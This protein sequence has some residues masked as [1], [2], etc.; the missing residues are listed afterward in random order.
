V[1]APALARGQVIAET[2]V[3][4]QAHVRRHGIRERQAATRARRD[5]LRATWPAAAAV[6]SVAATRRA[7]VDIAQRWQDQQAD[8]DQRE[9]MKSGDHQD[10]LIRA[11]HTE[12]LPRKTGLVNGFGNSSLPSTTAMATKTETSSLNVQRRE[13]AGS[14][15]VR[16]LRRAGNVPGVIYGGGADPVAFQVDARL[17]RNTLAHSHAV[18]ELQVESEKASPVVVKEVARHPVSGEITHIDL[19]RVRMDQKISTTVVLDLVGAESAPG[20]IEGGIL[21]QVTRELNI[22]ALPGDIPDAVH[23]DVSG[24]ESGAT[25]T[26]SEL[27]PPRGVAFLDDPELV[28]ATIT[29]PRLQLEDENEIEQETEVIGEGAPEGEAEAGEPEAAAA[30]AGEAAE[31]ESAPEE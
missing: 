15:A 24:L 19:L 31:G 21:E 28:V 18:L 11:R 26:L 6:V 20:V 14:R 13:V 3:V 2:G 27:T 8:A 12:S 17:L 16:R 1:H 4:A 30:G 5:Q 7:L 25:L 29:A 22:E 9:Q 23:H 10:H